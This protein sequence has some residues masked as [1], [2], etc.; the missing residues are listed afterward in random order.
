[1]RAYNN[2]NELI[3]NQS[4]SK[5]VVLPFDLSIQDSYIIKRFHD[6]LIKDKTCLSYYLGK[7]DKVFYFQFPT[8][9][10]KDMFIEILEAHFQSLNI[11]TKYERNNG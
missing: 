11:D 9:Q 3:A 10:F 2:Y 8:E 6:Y 1:M 7:I 4:N 5:P